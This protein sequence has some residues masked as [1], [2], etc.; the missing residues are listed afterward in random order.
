MNKK[1]VVMILFVFCLI[2]TI[3]IS[4]FG[5]LP[6]DASR[7]PVESIEFIDP[8]TEDGKCKLTSDG[9]KLIE[10]IF[11]TTE[12]QLNYK[13]NPDF[14]TEQDVKFVIV[15]GADY[16]TVSDTGLVTF[17][18]E[19]SITVKIYSNFFDNKTDE[20]IIE[21]VGEKIEV[22]DPTIDPFA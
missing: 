21:F 13:I 8:T 20:V 1:I 12:Y 2:A 17:E 6:E 9:D 15:N 14:A 7:T 3:L 10:V 18:K 22:I 11:G 4:V 19:Y 16:A 5:K